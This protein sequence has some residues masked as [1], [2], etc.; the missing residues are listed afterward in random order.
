[1]LGLKIISVIVIGATLSNV[2][3]A[4]DDK[5]CLQTNRIWGWQAVNDRTLVLT[6]RAYNRYT[7]DLTGGCIGLDHYAG[8]K[9]MMR[10]KTSL[11][12]L[13]QGDTIDFNSPGIGPL[14]CFV[15]SVRSGVPSAP[16]GPDA[17]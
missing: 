2:A 15:Q 8:T 10:T 6:D 4:A 13:S 7:V 9:L 3:L 14:S 17:H 12:C 16:P 1:M 5:A 11:G